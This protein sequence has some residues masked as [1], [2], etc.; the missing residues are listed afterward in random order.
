MMALLNQL[1]KGCAPCAQGAWGPKNEPRREVW[2]P[3]SPVS[4]LPVQLWPPCV[5]TFLLTL[6]GSATFMLGW[7]HGLQG[8]DMRYPGP[9]G[10]S[11][12]HASSMGCQE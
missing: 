7:E 8:P 3:S 12:A 1:F 5:F 11:R 2:L 4:S 10:L 9:K 6:Q